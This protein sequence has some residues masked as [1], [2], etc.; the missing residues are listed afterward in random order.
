MIPDGPRFR[1]ERVTDALDMNRADRRRAGFRG[2]AA[3]EHVG[4]ATLPRGV[5]RAYAR[6]TEK[7]FTRRQRKQRARVRR[8]LEKAMG[9]L[10]DQM[11]LS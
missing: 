3:V 2:P 11:R 10:D 9:C 4:S 8:G 5:A 1:G 6:M 7:P